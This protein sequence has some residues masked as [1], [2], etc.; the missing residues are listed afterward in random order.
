M[1]EAPEVVPDE[2]FMREATPYFPPKSEKEQQ[3]SVE[4]TIVFLFPFR[5]TV[6]L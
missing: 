2:F 5:H 6:V 1:G 3:Q 4:G